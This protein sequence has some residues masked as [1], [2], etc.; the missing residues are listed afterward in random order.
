MGIDLYCGDKTFGCSYGSWHNIRIELIKATFEYLEVH[1]AVTEYEEGTHEHGSM[2]ALKQ[3]I[4]KI[5]NGSIVKESIFSRKESN[6]LEL[7]TTYSSLLE[8]V[9]LLIQFG[10][11]GIYSLCNKSDCEGFYSVGNSYDICELLKLVKPFL[12]KNKEDLDAEENCLY[13]GIDNVTNIF[14]ESVEH[15]EIVRIC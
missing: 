6:L 7:F 2:I 5:Q 3:Y 12:L 4:E 1:F 8:F 11:G 9:D 15:N 13:N 14:K 10:V